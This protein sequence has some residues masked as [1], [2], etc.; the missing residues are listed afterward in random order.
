MKTLRRGISYNFACAIL[1]VNKYGV[2]DVKMVGK[3]H[4]F[5]RNSEKV[6]RYHEDTGR[7]QVRRS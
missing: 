3:W 2:T 7:L 4:I 6:A 1:E 5:Y